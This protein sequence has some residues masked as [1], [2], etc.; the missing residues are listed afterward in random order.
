MIPLILIALLIIASSTLALSLRN[1][2][3]SVLLLAATWAGVAIF[4]LWAGAEFVAFAQLLV[5][6]GAISMLALFAV[7]LTRR[8]LDDLD[9]QPESVSRAGWALLAGGG[10]AGVLLGAVLGSNLADFS[11]AAPELSVRELGLELAGPQAAALLVAALLL[12]VALIGGVV[13]AAK[14]RDEQS[15]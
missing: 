5:Y 2:V 1:L 8:S 10:V 6:V 13:L 4:F 7:L 3:H 14:E 12:T 15:K 9:Y 11:A